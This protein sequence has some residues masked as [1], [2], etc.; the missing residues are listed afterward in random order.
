M[1]SELSEKQTKLMF[2]VRDK[3]LDR[4]FDVDGK[5]KLDKKKT[6]ELIDWVYALAGYAA[7]EI[8]YA[9]SPMEAQ[10]IA[11]KLYRDNGE[12]SPS[13][14]DKYVTPSSAVG[15]SNFGWVAFY[16]FFTQIGVVNDE[17]FNRFAKYAELPIFDTIMLHDVCIVVQYPTSISFTVRNEI[18][19]LHNETGPAIQFSDGFSLYS[20][21]GYVVPEKWIMQKSKITK[22]DI[23][24]ENNAEARR[25]LMEILG[26]K[27][28]YDIL[29][30]GAGLELLDEDTDEQGNPMRLYQTANPDS[31]IN[32]RVQFLE[33]VDPSTGR[34]YNIY[35]PKQNAK[36][37]WD[38]K[39]QTF[40]DERLFVR[41]GDVG[42]VKTGYNGPRPVTET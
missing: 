34:V 27:K 3:W 5:Q 6:K 22:N 25:V 29:T 7:P 10:S 30:D 39:A 26:A 28:Y 18:R 11:N 1:L 16:D 2:S 14:P 40:N 9:A 33:V 12:I 24:S 17:K 41:H 37:V 42:L 19:V 32:K 15:I 8:I 31:V 20:W 35:P 13:G 36:N 23:L 21:N 38:A 4:A